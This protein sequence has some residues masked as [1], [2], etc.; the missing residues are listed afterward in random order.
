MGWDQAKEVAEK[1][2]GGGSYIKLENDG[3]KIVCAFL[4]EPHAKEV[5]WTGD[6]TELCEGED[7]K[8]CKKGPPQAKFSINLFVKTLFT[9]DR[10]GYDEEEIGE[11]RIF[12]QGIYFFNDLVS[13]EEKYGFTKYWFE[14]ERQ[15]KAKSTKT[16]YKINVL[17]EDK[18]TK[19]EKE[20]LGEVELFDLENPS[21]RNNDDDDNDDKEPESERKPRTSKSSKSSKRTSDDLIDTDE[22]QEIVTRLKMRPRE[23]LT[24][25]LKKFN[26]KR[27]KDIKQS[28]LKDV[29]AYI[30]ELEG[31]S[32]D[33]DDS[34]DDDVDP[35]G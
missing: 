4:G 15:G 10:K 34:D 16:R 23:E 35:F 27:I 8:L 29:L 20:M 6:G 2:R 22:S 7:C 26:I 1:S 24:G 32:D 28:Q 11:V 33:S 17:P 18:I 25:F 9:K 12:E 5:H 3:D 14:I 19:E 31:K 30:N 21:S 13:I